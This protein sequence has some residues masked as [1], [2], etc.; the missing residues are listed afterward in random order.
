MSRSW[1]MPC[2]NCKGG[3]N[4]ISRRVNF[5]PDIIKIILTGQSLRLTI[6]TIIIVKQQLKKKHGK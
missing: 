1:H 3:N 4:K 2:S 5:G 6:M